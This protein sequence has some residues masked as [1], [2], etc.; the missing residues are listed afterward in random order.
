LSDFQTAKL[1]SASQNQLLAH[2]GKIP[3]TVAG[4]D[5][6]FTC[7]VEIKR[8][9]D[10]FA[11]AQP[12]PFILPKGLRSGPQ[13]SMDVQI[14]TRTLEPGRYALLVSQPDG[15]A[16]P[17]D[18]KILPL[19]PKLQNLPILA[20]QGQDVQHYSLKGEHLDLLAKLEAP[21]AELKLESPIP[22]GAERNLA[23]QLKSNPP[24]GTTLPIQAFLTDRSAALTFPD[25]LQIT[26]PLP[27]IASSKLSLPGG[28]TVAILSEEV[29]AGATLT[30]LLDVKNMQPSSI[31]KLSCAE[32]IGAHPELHVGEQNAVS[33]LQQL[34]GDQLFMSYDT[35]AFPAGC[36]LQAVLDNGRSGESRPF[37]LAR[38]IRVPRI[39]SFDLDT[40][41]S[42]A[43]S[44]S[45]QQAFQL[46]GT[47]LEMI[48]KLGWD[49]NTGVDVAGLPTPLPG[50]G[51][52]QSLSVSL[53]VPPAPH[54]PLFVWL[55]NEK[56]A[57]Q[58][59]IQAPPG[60][61]ASS[62]GVPEPR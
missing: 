30:A 52:Q 13:E 18:F 23:V 38:V 16:H 40:N 24:P 15:E 22:G 54:A 55:R 17:I 49:A 42:P 19:P 31:L 14:D 39:A 32:D 51:Q 20:N 21:G 3:V 56:S 35:S 33:S 57:R 59:T 7:K 5:F 62:A 61:H 8:R 36:T 27:V 44:P 48:A 26:G 41:K 58:T 2:S 46:T 6:Q 37:P 12:A 50:Q 25:A 10:E 60:P 4:S 43:D 29:P 1:E 11:V 47:N 28:S 34:S 45:G 9:D 53:P